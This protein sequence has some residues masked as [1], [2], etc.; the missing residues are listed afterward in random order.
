MC[1]EKMPI[2]TNHFLD[3]KYILSYI[4]S[5]IKHAYIH[6]SM[7][8]RQQTKEYLFF[9]DNYLNVISKDTYAINDT[10]LFMDLKTLLSKKEFRLF[11]LKFLKEYSDTEIAALFHVSRQAV[12]KQ[13]HKLKSKLRNYIENKEYEGFY[14]H[15]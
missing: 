2:E 7:S 4:Q 6:L 8:K 10:L 14:E 12:N 11:Q 15:K 13:V 5:S 9:D 3:D 1:I